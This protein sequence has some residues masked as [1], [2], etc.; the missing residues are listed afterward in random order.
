M[1]ASPILLW[2]IFGDGCSIRQD[3]LPVNCFL[4]LSCND[5]APR[6]GDWTLCVPRRQLA[7]TQPMN[8]SEALWCGTTQGRRA[9]NL[10]STAEQRNEQQAACVALTKIA[11]LTRQSI[12]QCRARGDE[13]DGLGQYLAYCRT[14]SNAYQVRTHSCRPDQFSME[15]AP[16]ILVLLRNGKLTQ[17]AQ[18]RMLKGKDNLFFRHTGGQ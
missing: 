6:H 4:R 5:T 9:P 8:M 13:V 14:V 2:S 18:G 3:R 12:G 7:E 10:H 17:I 1:V 16:V 15:I 11:S